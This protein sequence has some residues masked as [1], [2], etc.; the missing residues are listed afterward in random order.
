[1]G[2]GK[3]TLVKEG[4]S[5]LPELTAQS[6]QSLLALRAFGTTSLLEVV[7]YLDK[8]GLVLNSHLV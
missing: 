8:L 3:T 4:I 2:N 1:M 6:K 5:T 7:S